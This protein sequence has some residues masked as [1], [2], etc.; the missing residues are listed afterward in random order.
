MFVSENLLAFLPSPPYSQCTLLPAPSS[1]WAL[2]LPTDI[3][4]LSGFLPAATV[5][6]AC[7]ARCLA[8]WAAASAGRVWNTCFGLLWNAGVCVPA[9][10]PS[11]CGSFYMVFYVKFFKANKEIKSNLSHLLGHCW[12]SFLTCSG[13]WISK[14]NVFFNTELLLILQFKFAGATAI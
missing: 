13:K 9:H 14:V 2:Y 4:S 11:S 8:C 10:P 3:S 12:I 5:S 6:S 1:S 7:L